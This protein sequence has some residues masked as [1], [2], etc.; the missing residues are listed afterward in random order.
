MPQYVYLTRPT[1]PAFAS[2]MTEAEMAIW[3]RHWDELLRRHREGSLILVGRTQDEPPIGITVFEAPDDAAA[4]AAMRSDPFV[5]EGL[6]IGELHPYRVA[7]LRGEP[8]E[9]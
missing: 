6:V 2:T 7:L 9:E 1:R 4:E 8:A 3:Q 5:G